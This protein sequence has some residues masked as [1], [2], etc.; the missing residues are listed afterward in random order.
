MVKQK[1]ILS[2]MSTDRRVLP[3]RVCPNLWSWLLIFPKR[4]PFP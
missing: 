3:P 2:V 1:V 4:A